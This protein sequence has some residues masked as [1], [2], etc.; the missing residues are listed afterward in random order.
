MPDL[1]DRRFFQ[2]LAALNAEDVCKRAGCAYEEN[3]RAY[4]LTLWDR[5]Y[6]ILPHLHQIGP[7]DS[8]APRLHP[9]FD[10][11]LV[12]YLLRANGAEPAERWIS[13][14]DIPGGATFFRG[15]HTIPTELIMTRFQNDIERFNTR[16]EQLQGVPLILADAAWRFA[17][18]PRVP[19]AVLYWRGDEEFPAEAKILFDAAIGSCMAA[20]VV[21]AL[22]TGIC[23]RLGREED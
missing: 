20:D 5:R 2:Q 1:I 6:R 13:E 21:Y 15:P 16:C 9:Y 19:V 3:D 22:A 10:L 12:H 23:D 4:A 17:I 11:F 7:A 8:A 18:T 14:K